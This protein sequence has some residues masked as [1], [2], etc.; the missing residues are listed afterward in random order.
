MIDDYNELRV[1]MPFRTVVISPRRD[2]SELAS[3]TD[4]WVPA[5]G[6]WVGD[7]PY[8]RRAEFASLCKS[9]RAVSDPKN[10]S[11]SGRRKMG[12]SEDRYTSLWNESNRVDSMDG[13]SRDNGSRKGDRDGSLMT[14][15][16]DSPYRSEYEAFDAAI[17]DVD[18]QIDADVDRNFD[19]F[20]EDDE[21]VDSIDEE[22][23]AGGDEMAASGVESLSTQ[24]GNR[25]RAAGNW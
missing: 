14:R 4:G 24:S 22:N 13:H 23:D 2:F 19:Q 12:R 18:S 11:S 21:Y 8:L 25:S 10:R 9:L 1:R 7:Y 5:R 17:D 3:V 15:G 16:G 20:S 6:V